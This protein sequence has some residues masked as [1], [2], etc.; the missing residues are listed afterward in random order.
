MTVED[1]YR[2]AE[3][4]AFMGRAPYPEEFIP[5]YEEYL[6]REKIRLERGVGARR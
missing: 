2:R 1:A 5:W 4:L 3:M 6:K